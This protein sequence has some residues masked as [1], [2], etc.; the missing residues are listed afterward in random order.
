MSK[1]YNKELLSKLVEESQSVSEVM[2][3]LGIKRTGGSHGYISKL[4]RKFEIDKSHFLGQGAH[5]GQKSNNNKKSW[6][7]VL[8]DGCD[9]RNYPW[10]LRRALLESGREYK[11]FKCGNDGTWK[12]EAIRLQ[13]EHKNGNCFDNRKENLEF[14]CPNCHSQAT[15]KMFHKGHT[16]LTKMKYISK[17]TKE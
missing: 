16:D 7:E 1:K 2:R 17:K 12:G 15:A 14:L 8:V 11:C 5:A 10:R 3:K 9:K 13:I 4:I 6:Q